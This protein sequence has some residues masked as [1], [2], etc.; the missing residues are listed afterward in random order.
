MT[1]S[2]LLCLSACLN[3]QG[4]HDLDLPLHLRLPLLLRL[5]DLHQRLRLPLLLR[6]HDLDHLSP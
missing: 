4:P 1:W 6:L 3:C 5:H 2:L